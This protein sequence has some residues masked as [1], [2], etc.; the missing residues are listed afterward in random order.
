MKEQLKR[1]AT[2]SKTMLVA[3]KIYHNWQFKKRFASGNPESLHGST[4]SRFDLSASL[5]YINAQF[6]DY[7]QYSGL[8]REWLKGRRIFELGFGDNIGV[9]LR[10]IAAGAAQV[11]CLDKFYAKR[12]TRNERQI[13]QHLRETLSDEEKKRFDEAVELK[14]GIKINADRIKCIYGVD[15]QDSEELKDAPPFDV[16]LSRGAIQDIFDPGPAFLAMDRLLRPGGYML[17]KIDLSDQGMFRRYGMNPLTF[18][19][20]S[21]SV[22]RMMAEGSGK[23]NRKKMSYYRELLDGLG[24]ETKILITDIIGRGG[25]GDLY[26]H[27]E[28]VEL[29]VDYSEAALK[30]VRQVRPKLSP[31]F[32]QMTD[33]ELM[34]DGIFIIARKKGAV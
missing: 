31:A 23:P 18:L 34:V 15:V 24:Y 20:I 14:D 26:P 21:D 28:S 9:A 2:K 32:R 22:Y 17:H 8:S 13:Y 12:D 25:K 11:V 6:D 30:L 19:T 7:L 33:E 27:R 1:A 16:A 3:Y 4:H 29:H 10:F 5:N